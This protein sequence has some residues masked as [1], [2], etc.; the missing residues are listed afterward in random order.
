MKTK[1]IHL[2]RIINL[3]FKGLFSFAALMSV[4]ILVPIMAHALTPVTM[5]WNANDP[6]PD[7]YILYWGTSNGNYTNSHDVGNATQYTI[8]DLQEGVT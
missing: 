3:L 7:G 8:P 5:A 2:S 1:K 6:V 4:L